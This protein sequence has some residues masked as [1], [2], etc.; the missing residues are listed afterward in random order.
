M[1]AELVDGAFRHHA[2]AGDNADAVAQALHQIQLVGGEDDGHALARAVCKHRAHHVHGDG[3]EAGERFIQNQHIR[4]VDQGRR[5][6]DALAMRVVNA[7]GLT[8]AQ[9]IETLQKIVDRKAELNRE[10]QRAGARDI[11][12]GNRTHEQSEEHF[13]AARKALAGKTTVQEALQAVRS[14][15][16]RRQRGLIDS[17]LATGAL[18]NVKFATDHQ[19]FGGRSPM[20][21]R[22]Y[23]IHNS[24]PQQ[25]ALDSTVAIK[26]AEWAQYGDQNT[27]IVGL[28]I[29]EATH[30][31]TSHAELTDASSRAALKQMLDHA[32][33]QL[34]KAGYDVDSWYGL[35]ETQEFIA[36]AFGNADFQR[37]LLRE[38]V[39]AGYARF[40]APDAAPTL[41]LR[42]MAREPHTVDAFFA[43]RI[44]FP[45]I[46]DV[47]GEVL[48]GADGEPLHLDP[49][50]RQPTDPPD[51]GGGP[52][53][54]PRDEGLP[55]WPRSSEVTRPER[56][57][58]PAHRNAHP[59][60]VHLG[61]VMQELVQAVGPAAA[62][63]DRVQ[64][65]LER[66]EH[67][68]QT[69]A[70]RLGN[71]LGTGEPRDGG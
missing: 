25:R 65:G 17:L 28:L 48:A 21:G 62:R 39:V 54:S 56:I 68:V 22:A 6:L 42:A 52:Q 7:A 8:E 3:I 26:M 46:V 45:E 59:V 16:N 61:P 12:E 20:E 10:I 24:T 58:G 67:W 32:R 13:E 9:R 37:L 66:G 51:D 44:R 49:H 70:G 1:V 71:G 47:I 41:L 4:V 30:A 34:T 64:K 60:E 63:R 15:G 57:R 18:R 5:E 55:H 43:E 2:S 36:E 11:E 38:G 50:G 40:D 29:H 31:A 33:E 53:P 23:G 14:L 27:D 35:A 69:L 19:A